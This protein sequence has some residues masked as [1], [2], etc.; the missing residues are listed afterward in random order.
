MRLVRCRHQ[1]FIDQSARLVVSAQTTLFHDDFYFFAELF[2][3]QAQVG[4]AIRFEL[5][6]QL[7]LRRMHLL[8]IG[9]VVAAGEGILAPARRCDALG[10]FARL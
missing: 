2:I 1:G 7:K 5:H 4:H 6:H 9:G 8:K 10:E 3:G